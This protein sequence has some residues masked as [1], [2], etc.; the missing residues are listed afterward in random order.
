MSIDPTNVP[1]YPVYQLLYEERP[2]DTDPAGA[3]TRVEL[4]GI[5]VEPAVGQTAT[6]AAIAAVARKAADHGRQA[7]RVM[8]TTP[9][10]DRW[11]MVVTRDGEAID[12]PEPDTGNRTRTKK[13]LIITA[14][15]LLAIAAAGG[16]A[17]VIVT[18]EDDPAPA[19]E[20]GPRDHWQPPNAGAQVPVGLP[21]T[22]S[23]TAAWAWSVS[24][25]SGALSLSDGTIVIRDAEGSLVGLD[26]ED[27]RQLWH[28][29]AAPRETT[30]LKETTWAGNSVLADAGTQRLQLWPLPT[31]TTD[32]PVKPTTIELS[33]RAEVSFAGDAPLIYLGDYVVLADAGDGT[34]TEVEVP[35]GAHPVL[36]AEGNVVS[37]D[38]DHVYR[39]PITGDEDTTSTSTEL[40]HN[41]AV[42]DERPQAIWPLAQDVVAALYEGNDGDP[43]LQ[44]FTITD[45]ERIAARHL[46]SAPREQDDVLVDPDAETAVIGSAAIR[47]GEEEDA[48]TQ[49]TTLR[50]PLLHGTT[51]WG[52]TSDGPARV[53]ISADGAEPEPYDTLSDSDP[54]PV[55]ITDDAAYVEAPRV[56]D[57]FLYRVEH[58]ASRPDPTEETEDA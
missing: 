47:W 24:R 57:T 27:G 49:T 10:G 13:P 42:Q 50:D 40:K 31:E 30:S 22:Y 7:V 39:T 14:A 44:V 32:E 37:F 28:S 29:P 36:V 12:V 16:A 51:L 11:A 18:N 20:A 17:A 52:Q 23:P 26:P 34:L 55:L 48:I 38:A 3:Q 19:V 8:V 58:Q 2:N 4:D 33:N 6:E 35:A 46:E 54:V 45:G 41:S 15:V 25:D 9:E 56:T 21:D 53:D 1:K 43:L 5:R